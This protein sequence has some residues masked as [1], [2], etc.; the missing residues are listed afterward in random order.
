MTRRRR[1]TQP[2]ARARRQRRCRAFGS[3]T[4][5]GPACPSTIQR[6]LG[7]P[8]PRQSGLWSAGRWRDRSVWPG[9]PAQARSHASAQSSRPRADPSRVPK[10]PKTTLQDHS[11]ALKPY[12]STLLFHPLRAPCLK[13]HPG[14]LSDHN[15]AWSVTQTASCVP[16][17]RARRAALRPPI[18]SLCTLPAAPGSPPCRPR[19]A[20]RRRSRAACRPV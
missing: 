2:L 1:A 4:A 3:S 10:I 7:R 17:H 20:P 19:S 16:T 18:A 15:S 12:Y 13:H 6:P 11:T 8:P 9:R 5:T 14:R